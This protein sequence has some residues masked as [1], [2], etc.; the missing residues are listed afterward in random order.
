MERIK[1]GMG[2]KRDMNMA[3]IRGWIVLAMDVL[4]I[5]VC[6]ILMFLPA[7]LRNDIR[8][9]NL[10]LHIGFLTAC[11]LVFQVVFKTY[12]S[13]WRYAESREYLCLLS[14]LAAGF[15]LYAGLNLLMG[16][17]RIWIVS[18]FFGTVIAL[19]IMLAYRFAYRMLR[20][21]LAGAPGKGKRQVAIIGTGTAGVSLLYELMHNTGGN[22]APYCLLDDASD[23]IGKVV[24]GVPVKGP[25]N[26]L[27]A[28]LQD[29]PVTE[30][31]L[32]I[33]S[34]TAA[35]KAEILELCSKTKCRLHILSDPIKQ[36]EGNAGSIM[37]SNV[38]EVE[39]EDL[40]GRDPVQL[41]KAS[42][43]AFLAGKRVLV[44]GGGGSIGSE[45]CRQIAEC[46]PARLIAVDISENS[47]YDLQQELLH[48]FQ[49][50]LD[51]VV[52]IASVRD[53]EKMDKLFG[54]YQPQ[55]VF[56][57]AAHKH[58]PLMEQCPEEAIKNNVFGTYN[59]ALA[60]RKHKAEAFVLISTDKA[61]NPTNIMGATK[62][63]CEQVLQGLRENAETKFAA[64]R[65]GNVLGSNGSVIPLFKK[66][67]AYGGPVTITDKRIIRY[68]MTIP[69]AVQLVLEAGSLAQSGEVFVLD[70]GKPVRIL[71]LAENLIRLSG[72]TPYQDIQIEEIGLRPGE[73]LYEELL[74]RSADLS[75]TEND[76]I[77]VEF[78][79]VIPE[80]ALERRLA[81][82]TVVLEH[83]RRADIFQTLHHLV[84][85][86]H[87]PE[88]VNRAALS[89]MAEAAP[90]E[91]TEGEEEAETEPRPFELGMLRHIG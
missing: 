90:A 18:A 5:F 78:K 24:Q 67:I 30:I 40:L 69:E 57:A 83:G 20:F 22:Y 21:R 13:L 10:I 31:I 71:E 84:P 29:T 27:C 61:V 58:V 52:E 42:V 49:N 47:V 68:F 11:V 50:R 48:K 38:R 7:Y 2:E 64:V 6:N 91:D 33:P 51:F 34:L 53:R 16:A 76:K 88:E 77:F 79:P 75:R 74:T 44:T 25:I 32:A 43:R 19:V 12:E 17:Q 55:V 82:L 60:A 65:F 39:I 37:A 46:G 62:Y 80:A 56:H 87:D 3:R 81:E 73:K 59:T 9:I 14:G 26:D 28:I 86:F 89:R 1:S 66:Q 4:T 23:K 72:L 41:D 15:V 8:L 36:L 63:L 45:L 70:M 35:R 85:T 54:L